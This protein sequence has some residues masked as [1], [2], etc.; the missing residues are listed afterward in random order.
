MSDERVDIESKL[1]LIGS[2]SNEHGGVW[3]YDPTHRAII[4]KHRDLPGTTTEIF[5]RTRKVKPGT[6]ESPTRLEATAKLDN[7]QENVQQYIG[8]AE[9]YP[10]F[11]FESI[12]LLDHHGVPRFTT[13]NGGESEVTE[14]PNLDMTSWREYV[15]EWTDEPA[16]TLFIDGEKRAEHTTHVPTVPLL[17][18]AEIINKSETGPTEA[19]TVSLKAESLFG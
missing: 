11:F 17:R 5:H 9:R 15:V 12:F 16:A 8:F 4:I 14:F 1:H 6:R 7:Q 18:F 13:H 3:I 2:K 10:S 19:V